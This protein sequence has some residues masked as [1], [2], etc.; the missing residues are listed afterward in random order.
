MKF[1][2]IVF[3]LSSLLVANQTF[4]AELLIKVTGITNAEGNMQIALFNNEASFS[5][6][7]YE[8]MSVP[9]TDVNMQVQISDLAAGEYAIMLFQ[10]LDSNEELDTN[11]LGIP[12]E[13]WGGSLQ[14]KTIMRAPTW[15]DVKFT[16]DSDV[17]MTVELN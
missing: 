8:A 1:T 14:G 15:N 17:T 11:L 5:D 2:A 9:V 6:S 3:S 13:P 10:D 16:V 7:P 12:R 4:A